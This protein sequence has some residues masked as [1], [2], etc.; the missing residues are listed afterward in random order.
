MVSDGYGVYQSRSI[1]SSLSKVGDGVHEHEKASKRL[2]SLQVMS[3]ATD[4][5]HT[6][7][8]PDLTRYKLL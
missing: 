1:Y 5:R 2:A 4:R 7:P 3:P 6:A 8:P